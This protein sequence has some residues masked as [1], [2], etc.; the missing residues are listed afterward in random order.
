MPQSIDAELGCSSHITWPAGAAQTLRALSPLGAMLVPLIR[1][2]HPFAPAPVWMAAEI[3]PLC[4]GCPFRCDGC[5]WDWM[6][7]GVEPQLL[8]SR[9][10]LARRELGL[11]EDEFVEMVTERFGPTLSS[12]ESDSGSEHDVIICDNEPG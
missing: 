11:D 4:D 3:E 7:E 10:R 2:L 8:L 9:D 6:D 1:A 5:P 12:R